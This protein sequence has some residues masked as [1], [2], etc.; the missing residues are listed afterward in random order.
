MKKNL[1]YIL[2]GLSMLSFFGCQQEDDVEKSIERQPITSVQASFTE[3]D[4]SLENAP[5]A[6]FKTVIDNP[7]VTKIVVRVPWYYPEE[8]DNLTSITRMRVRA[9]LDNNCKLVP[10]LTILDLTKENNFKLILPNGSS[11]DVVITGEIYKLTSCNITYFAIEDAVNEISVTGAID[12]A[13]GTISL[14]SP[15]DLSSVKVDLSLSP[16]ATV[17]QDVENKVYNFNSPVEFTVIA[18][19]G[20][21]KKTYTVKKEIPNKVGYGFAPGTETD[22]WS[23]NPVD[24]GLNWGT[25]QTT[26]AAIG[27][28]L[29]LSNGNSSTPVYLNRMTGEKLGNIV[30]GSASATG[31]VTNDNNDNLIISNTAQP[32]D[33]LNI[34]RTKSVKRAPVLYLSYSN[35]SGLPISRI[36]VQGNLDGEGQIIATCDGIPG[37]STSNKVVRWKISGGVAGVAEVVSFAGVSAWGGAATNT[38]VAPVSVKSADG[39][40]TAAYD[41]NKIYYV[42]GDTNAGTSTVAD[43]SGNSWAMNLNRLDVRTFNNARYMLAGSMPHFPQWGIRGMVYLFDITNVSTLTGDVANSPALAFKSALGSN[44]ASG[45][46]ISANGDVLLV[47]SSNGFYLHLYYWDNNSKIVGAYSFNCIEQ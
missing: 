24:L 22:L 16:H 9:E 27:N 33:K 11:R 31:C 34:Y 21:T 35:T 42:N 41:S 1:L 32:G 38:Q 39:Y 12:D 45:D 36:R 10:E 15:D 29:I 4:Y 40:F 30:L 47:P 25:G 44:L 17:D 3:G 2:T 6:I 46:G 5:N 43:G 8:S 37:V 14:I 20:V 13:K 19:D 23:L 28:Y 18:H 7:D 26:L